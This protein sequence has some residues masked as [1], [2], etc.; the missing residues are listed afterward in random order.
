MG[1]RLVVCSRHLHHLTL[2]TAHQKN[3]VALT[4]LARFLAA[5]ATLLKLLQVLDLAHLLA[6]NLVHTAASLSLV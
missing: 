6:L 4:E 1:H 2:R 3:L 5:L